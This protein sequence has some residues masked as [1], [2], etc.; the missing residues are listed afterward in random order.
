MSLCSS[1][2]SATPLPPPTRCVHNSCHAHPHGTNPWH[3]TGQ[4][5]VFLTQE[6][7]LTGTISQDP[8]LGTSSSGRTENSPNTSCRGWC[9]PTTAQPSPSY[10]HV[11][12]LPGPKN[13]PCP[14]LWGPWQQDAAPCSRCQHSEPP[15]S[16]LAT[17]DAWHFRAEA[18]QKWQTGLQSKWKRVQKCL[19]SGWEL[20]GLE[21][22][23]WAL[24]Q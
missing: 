22:E 4:G 21:A 3:V 14:W 12:H 23:S 7:Q 19:W 16:M 13:P 15:F 20:P 5:F 8:V 10:P 18:F 6:E 11:L 9:P 1:W 2:R 24:L 17:R